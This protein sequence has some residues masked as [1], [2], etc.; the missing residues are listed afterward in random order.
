MN[1]E[2]RIYVGN[3][4]ED[5]TATAL[6]LRFEQ[7]GMVRD[8]ELGIDR[9]SGRMRGFA[10]VTM[11][12]E[13]SYRAALTQLDGALFEDRVLRVCEPGEERTDGAG[14][15]GRGKK[16]PAR[17]TRIIS[18]FRE[19]TCMAIEL[20][21]SGTPLSFKMYPTQQENGDEVWRVDATCASNAPEPLVLASGATRRQAFQLIERAWGASALDWRS[22]EEALASVRAI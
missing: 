5:I 3:L 15:G 8:V 16:E 6:R 1:V 11:A 22:I 19:R 17:R 18:Q 9:A 7:V 4:A 13:P 10:F 20:E 21:S 12:D 14:R 2:H